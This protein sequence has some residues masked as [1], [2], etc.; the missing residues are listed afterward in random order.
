VRRLFHKLYGA[1]IVA[2]LVSVC[3]GA[4]TAAMVHDK[5]PMRNINHAAIFRVAQALKKD[6]AALKEA[7]EALA[8]S[9][10]VAVAVFG[11][12]KKM[13][14][15]SGG[16]TPLPEE[17]GD[18]WL[19]D[20]ELGKGG[21]AFGL[22]EG[23][24]LVIAGPPRSLLKTV[25]D[26]LTILVVIG[27]VLALAAF[28]IARHLTWRIEA[29]KI[30]VE[31][32]GEGD[33]TA[34]VEV[35]GADEVAQLA[36]S[37]N[38]A[39]ERIEALMESQRRMLASA[40]HELRSPLARIRLAIELLGDESVQQAKLS[41]GVQ[42]DIEE[43]DQLIDDLLLASRLQ[44]GGLPRQ[45]DTVYLLDIAREEAERVEATT[46]G[47]AEIVGDKRMMRRLIRNLLENA[48]RYGAPPIEV[49]LSL[50][51]LEVIDHGAGIAESEQQRIFEPFYRPRGHAETRDGGVGLGLSLVRDIAT[52]HGAEV[53]CV[54]QGDET[55]F[56]VKW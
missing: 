27:V 31:T 51:K 34:R 18:H 55:R 13:K 8:V 50:G 14:A 19:W 37:F 10:G 41:E 30:G 33:L 39:A 5:P 15:S 54:S 35:R 20:H 16:E 32:L 22:P 44:S 28:P 6:D 56:I 12:D 47:H 40:S 3:S 48:K 52:H 26:L 46:T 45:T 17:A 49:H 21:F 9:E 36:L 7:V 29:L 2:V 38:R 43:L 24:W 1:L 4:L 11:Q 25:Q 23:G 42:R 53:S